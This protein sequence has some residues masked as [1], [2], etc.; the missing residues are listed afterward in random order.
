MLEAWFWFPLIQM[1]K[2]HSNISIEG[3]NTY[4]N[5]SKMRHSGRQAPFWEFGG[6]VCDDSWGNPLWGHAGRETD[7]EKARQ[8][9]SRWSHQSSCSKKLRH[10]CAGRRLSQGGASLSSQLDHDTHARPLRLHQSACSSHAPQPLTPP[11][12]LSRPR[13]QTAR[14]KVHC[15][16]LSTV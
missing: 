7:R 16:T 12:S 9:A 13:V 15:H 10:G 2:G 11:F 8:K 5:G 6:N 3:S 4:G 1:R 14:L